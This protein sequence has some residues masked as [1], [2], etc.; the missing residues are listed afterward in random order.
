MTLPGERCS[1]NTPNFPRGRCPPDTPHPRGLRLL[2][3]LRPWEAAPPKP[4]ALWVLRPQT[5]ALGGCAPTAAVASFLD[6][7]VSSFKYSFV[8]TN[9]Y[10]MVKHS[11]QG[12]TPLQGFGGA[13]LK[14]RSLGAQ[15][16]TCGGLGGAAPQ[17]AVDPGSAAP[18]VRG[19]APSGKRCVAYCRLKNSTLCMC[20]VYSSIYSGTLDKNPPLDLTEGTRRLDLRSDIGALYLKPLHIRV[21]YIGALYLRPNI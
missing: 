16:R 10:S 9:E 11:N 3:K 5:P 8:I 2:D 18:R 20:M 17:G 13:A 4:A 7:N 6:Y 14:C 1:L 12:A 21:L 19:A 15:P